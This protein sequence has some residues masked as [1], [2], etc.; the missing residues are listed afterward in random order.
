MQPGNWSNRW[1]QTVR[2][3][4]VGLESDNS[5]RERF[6]V[7]GDPAGV[8]RVQNRTLRKFRQFPQR[9]G[10]SIYPNYRPRISN[11]MTGPDELN[12]SM[13]FLRRSR[14]GTRARRRGPVVEVRSLFVNFA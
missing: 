5:C 6:P 14:W 3:P 10:G 4:D 9:P 11:G 12:S 2:D 1:L 13:R 7:R 8:L